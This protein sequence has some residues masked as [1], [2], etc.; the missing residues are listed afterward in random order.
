M[1]NDDDDFAAMF[2]ESEKTPKRKD[3]QVGDEV[4][5]RVVSIG[6]DSVFLEVGA[7]SD[8]MVELN[9]LRDAEGKVGVKVG[10]ELEARV[11]ETGDRSGVI[12]LRRAFGRGGAVGSEELA[13]AYEHQI[14]VEGTV[15]A[16]NKGGVEV[17]VG[18]V[19]GFCPISQL[20]SRHVEDAS[21]YVGQKLT[22]R[23]TRYETGGRSVNVIV[24]R[25]AILD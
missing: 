8:G 10:D 11:V 2:A 18:G 12:V 25:R 16:V 7:K 14:P 1:A 4:R 21:G 9:E 20:E 13:Q 5:G 15:T 3:P 17:M 23:I 6:R 19:R 22:F 24:S